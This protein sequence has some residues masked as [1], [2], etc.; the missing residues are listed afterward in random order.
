ME[1]IILF[2]LGLI[3]AS[4]LTALSY[5]LEKEIPIK[6]FFKERSFC[7]SCHKQLYWYELIPIFS[8]VY[9]KGKCTKC[10]GRIPVYYPISEIFLSIS[11]VLIYLSFGL[12]IWIYVIFSLLFM[13]SYFDIISQTIPRVVAHLCLSLGIIYFMINYQSLSIYSPILAFV[14]ILILVIINIFRKS[15]G[16]GDMI[17]LFS[18]SLFFTPGK[19]LVF[20][21]T[22]LYTSAIYAIYLVIKDRKNLKSYIPL[23]PFITLSFLLTPFFEKLFVEYILPIW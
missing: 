17:L 20:L 6:H 10:K 5:R 12:N 9:Q 11:Y 4:F 1:Y 2:F 7:D 3:M 18:I 23:V 13:L 16:F 8:F 14:I 21:I 15:F 22:L 19:F